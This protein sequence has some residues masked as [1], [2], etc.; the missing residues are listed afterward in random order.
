MNKTVVTIGALALLGIG[1]YFAW[2]KFGKKDDEGADISDDELKSAVATSE[3]EETP[4]TEEDVE[5]EIDLEAEKKADEI[6][7]ASDIAEE[8]EDSKK[9]LPP[10]VREERKKLR[11]ERRRKRLERKKA[12]INK[13]AQRRSESKEKRIKNRGQ[14]KKAA[15][16]IVGVAVPAVG[17][18]LLANKAIK[19]IKAGQA[20]RKESRKDRRQE[21][22]DRRKRRFA[23]SEETFMNFNNAQSC[24]NFSSENEDFAFNGIDF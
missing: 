13:R 21:R 2:K 16:A 5:N 22:K 8:A 15:K 23:F 4:A 11:E 18:G 10:S 6:A 19:G 1:G 24:K 20:D 14:R 12:R 3:D 9:D 17:A 7:E